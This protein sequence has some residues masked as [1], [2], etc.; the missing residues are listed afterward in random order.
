VF[1]SSRI[2]Y[3]GGVLSIF[4]FSYSSIGVISVSEDAPFANCEMQKGKDV[5]SI[6]MM[7]EQYGLSTGIVSTARITHATPATAYAHASSRGWEN[8]VKTTNKNCS[9]IGGLV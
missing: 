3:E 9:D 1:T 5:L 2:I 4:F 8:D 6:V 7:A